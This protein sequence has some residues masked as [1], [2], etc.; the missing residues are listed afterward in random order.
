MTKNSF[1]ICDLLKRLSLLLG[2][3]VFTFV[4]ISG[5]SLLAAEAK[6]IR[7]L[8]ITGGCCHDY[9]KQRIIIPEGVSARANVVWTVVQ[10]GG[11]STDHRISVYEKAGWAEGYDVIVHN[12]CFADVNDAAFIENALRPHRDGTGAVVIH[13]TMHTF[14]ALKANDWREFLGVTST[15]H[16]AQ[17]R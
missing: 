15:H 8:L 6:P 14:R 2:A 5:A 7:A 16:G 13:C 1:P 9:N 17:H 10:E 11:N 12:E 3:S 4:P